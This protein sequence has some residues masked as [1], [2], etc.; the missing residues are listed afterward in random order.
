LGAVFLGVGETGG[1]LFGDFALEGF[2]RLAEVF[3]APFRFFAIGESLGLASY[4]VTSST[5]SED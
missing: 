1:L 4:I 3:F 2:D 5:V